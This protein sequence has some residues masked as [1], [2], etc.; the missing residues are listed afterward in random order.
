VY[1]NDFLINWEWLDV[2][3]KAAHDDNIAPS[4]Q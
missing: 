1:A 4:D 2:T 3:I